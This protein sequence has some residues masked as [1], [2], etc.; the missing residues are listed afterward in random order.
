MRE[1]TAAPA[2]LWWRLIE[3]RLARVQ[4]SLPRDLLG[5]I[6]LRLGD[7]PD[8]T[9]RTLSLGAPKVGAPHAVIELSSEGAL[10]LLEG[11]DGARGQLR[12]SG[13]RAVVERFFRALQAAP[14]SSSWLGIR[15][16]DE[17]LQSNQR[18]PQA[19]RHPVR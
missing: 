5:T 11:G 16:K 15:R 17:A 18:R 2:L 1:M 8:E 9:S 3:A 13:D 6:E 4:A 10:A 12:V 14:A 7:A 19:P